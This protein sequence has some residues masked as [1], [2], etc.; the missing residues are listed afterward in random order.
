MSGTGFSMDIY[1]CHNSI[2]LGIRALARIPTT[3][4]IWSLTMP[5][6]ARQV[7]ELPVRMRTGD[8]SQRMAVG[9]RPSDR[10]QASTLSRQVTIVH[11]LEKNRSLGKKP[12]I[13]S[14]RP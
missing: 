6:D 1:M 14:I 10:L 5:N 4:M 12:S 7:L 2:L 8:F 9:L 11:K 3:T 13:S